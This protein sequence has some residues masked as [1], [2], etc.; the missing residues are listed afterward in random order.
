M[1]SE[2]LAQNLKHVNMIQD[3][4]KGESGG[5]GKDFFEYLAMQLDPDLREHMLD[6]FINELHKMSGIFD[7]TKLDLG[8][9][10]SGTA[11]KFRI[12]PMDLKASEKVAYRLEFLRHRYKLITGIINQYAVAG[13][14]TTANIDD[15]EITM[16]RNI[17]DNI[18]AILEENNLMGMDVDTKTK[19]ERI[20]N[21]DPEEV[22]KRKE[23]ESESQP[24][25]IDTAEDGDV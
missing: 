2:E 24:F 17:P 9:D 16:K 23:E 21:I 18:K 19:L 22:M 1:N 10:P 6:H 3:M 13:V 8:Q 14:K 20:P 7:F 4:N 15:L 12:Y 5:E 11:L 25:E